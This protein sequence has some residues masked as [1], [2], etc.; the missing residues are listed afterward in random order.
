[1]AAGGKGKRRQKR[2]ARKRKS[3]VGLV[4]PTNIKHDP[5]RVKE[6]KKER[7]ARAP[8]TKALHEK[9]KEQQRANPKRDIFV[10]SKK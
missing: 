1:M 3:Q 2:R 4:L 9:L 6:L 5:E 7:K 10:D 8:L